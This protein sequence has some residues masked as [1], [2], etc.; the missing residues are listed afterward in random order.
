[1]S[2]ATLDLSFGHAWRAEV[3][4]ARPAILP[5]R[6]YVYPARAEEV[7][8]GALEV[9]VSPGAH[10]LPSPG[11]AAERATAERFLATCALGFADPAV[12]T[13]VWAC[14]DPDRMCAVAGGYAYLIDTRAPERFTFLGLRPVLSIHTAVEAGLL[15]FAGH[16]TVVAW[17]RAGLR[18]ESERLSDE[19][20]TEVRVEGGLLRG[21]G[22]EMA[23]DREREF[24]VDL[25]SGRRIG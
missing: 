11:S 19:G 23:A 2:A 3:L 25:E 15:L 20:L 10:P 5:A 12:P 24:A 22:W 9:M 16:R 7:E 13:G 6:N 17:G 1:M 14:P 8:R 21:M 18:W 4:T